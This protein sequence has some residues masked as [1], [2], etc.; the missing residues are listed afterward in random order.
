MPQFAEKW[1]VPFE[2]VKYE[3]FNFKEGEL[4]NENKL[5]ELADYRSYKEHTQNALIKLKFYRKLIEEF[6]EAL[7]PEISPLLEK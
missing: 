2:A 1:F 6:K 4:A 5:K 7:I 3:V